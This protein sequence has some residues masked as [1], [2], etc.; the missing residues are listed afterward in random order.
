MRKKEK[1]EKCVFFAG[2]GDGNVIAGVGNWSFSLLI[3]RLLC[4]RG[5][6]SSGHVIEVPFIG[7]D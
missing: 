7:T 5:L 6:Q 3:T 4:S 1:R 2:G